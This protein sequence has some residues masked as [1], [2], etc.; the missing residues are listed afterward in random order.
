MSIFWVTFA[1][2]ALFFLFVVARA[3]PAYTFALAVLI[4]LVSFFPIMWGGV[5]S[6]FDF[7]TY[8][9]F[10]FVGF[11]NIIQAFGDPGLKLS[12]KITA[13]WAVTVVM[14]KIFFSYTLAL[15]I[16]NLKKFSKLFYTLTLT[17]WAIPTYISIVAW[18]VLIEGYGGSSLISHILMTNLDLSSNVTAAFFSTAFVSAWLGVP[19]MT[20]VILS[21]MQSI[22]K[23][24]RDLSQMEGMDPLEKALNLY[25]PYT[26]PVA[27]PYIFLSFLGSF[28]EFTVFFLMTGGG[29]SLTSGFGSQTIVG[30]TTSLGMLVYSK[31]YSTRNYGVVGAYS[32]AIGL[33]MVM[34]LLIG[35]NYHFKAKKSHIILSAIFAH[36]IFDVWGMGSGLFS[37]VVLSLYIFSYVR[38]IERKTHFKD[39]F[40]V[41][42]TLDV[43]HM[44]VMMRLLGFVGISVSAILSF[45]VALT[46][47][48]H[49]KIHVNRLKVK[50]LLWKFL[51][52]SWLLLW[53]TGVVLPLLTVVY[54]AFSKVNTIPFDN[55]IPKAVTLE[56][57][58]A[59]FKDY[60]FLN[61]IKNS[62]EIGA[63]SVSI[64]LL[65]VFPAAWASLDS[66]GALR[67]GKVVT[68]AS[69]FTGMHTLIP[70]V[71]TYKFIGL[72]NT[73]FGISTAVAAHSSVFAYFLI[74]PF[75]RS[76]P[77][78]LNEAA[79]IDG[80]GGFRRMTKIY[81]PLSIPIL[82]T[83]GIYVFVE[84]WNS[85]IFPLVLLNSQR[86][87]PVS[88][89]LYNFIGEYGVSY[90]KW[91]LFGAGSVL[92][93]L[94][95]GAIFVLSRKHIVN[96]ILA[97]GGIQN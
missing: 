4:F 40:L 57:F 62:L 25:L 76:I 87:Y 31:F 94:I 20:L 71:M 56:N 19:M 55:L 17:P 64:V 11:K 97:K 1:I 89:M 13:L 30:A 14:L 15:S 77:R 9:S 83:V 42:A 70:L 61:A 43:L 75:L 49:G 47:S 5:V 84:A 32:L 54:M 91:N 53:A 96:G 24:L 37:M 52:F 41:G 35:W 50:P 65:T 8:A 95:V 86:L 36:F 60:N 45:V 82:T 67:F 59:L 90:S 58:F 88:I 3:K 68:F 46:L 80:A 18:T 21:S 92:N 2:S 12:A 79:K 51:K 16:S 93:L 72:S 28:K 63:L 74:F 81:L 44:M 66:K 27:F 33:I 22:P 69:F 85:F 39:V 34:L 29:P 10:H 6:F 38:C 48:F 26:L 23:G 7:F 73:L 78:S